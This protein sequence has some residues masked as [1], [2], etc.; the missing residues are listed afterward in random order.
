MLLRDIS[1]HWPLHINPQMDRRL[2]RTVELLAGEQPTSIDRVVVDAVLGVIAR[3]LIDPATDVNDE[4]VRRLI[5]TMAVD[6]AK[7]LG[8]EASRSW[9]NQPASPSPRARR[10]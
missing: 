10:L 3:P 4:R 2:K 7:R 8:N 1:S 9:N 6:V 5:I